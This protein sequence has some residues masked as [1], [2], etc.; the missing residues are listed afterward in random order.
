MSEEEYQ[1]RSNFL[2][3]KLDQLI[4]QEKESTNRTTN[5]DNKT[6]LHYWG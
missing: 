2:Q 1:G 5:N 4:Q 6:P 3:N